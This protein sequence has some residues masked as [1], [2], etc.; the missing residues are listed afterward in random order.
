MVK[1]SQMVCCCSLGTTLW[2]H[3]LNPLLINY[4]KILLTFIPPSICSVFLLHEEENSDHK[5]S[6]GARL[7]W[8]WIFIYCA[9]LN[10]ILNI[11][12][13]QCPHLVKT[14]KW[15]YQVSLLKICPNEIIKDVKK[16]VC[17]MMCVVELAII[18]QSGNICSVTLELSNNGKLVTK[19]CYATINKR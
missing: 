14:W 19:K 17:I 6:S 9:T 12:E 16:D 1:Q 2:E 5:T 11:T 8:V 13:F 18:V 15:F 4:C 3:C 7:N 10:K